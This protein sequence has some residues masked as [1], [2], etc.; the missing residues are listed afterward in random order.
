MKFF[1]E[2][3]DFLGTGMAVMSFR[4]VSS[5]KREAGTMT[6]AKD[7]GPQNRQ[8]IRAQIDENL[9][10]VY[11]TA[12]NEELPDRFRELLAQLK[13][14]DVPGKGPGAGNGGAQ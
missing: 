1:L 11:D 4:M 9:K 13:A 5:G 3:R 10:R 6:K 8:A 7:T 2:R 12:L 14:Q